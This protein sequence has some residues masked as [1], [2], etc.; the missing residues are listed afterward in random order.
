M[1]S[2]TS[3]KSIV[4]TGYGV[5]RAR[6]LRRRGAAGSAAPASPRRRCIHTWR[7]RVARGARCVGARWGRGAR[8]RLGE[9]GRRALDDDA[10][11]AMQPDHLD[12]APD[13]RLGAAYEQQPAGAAQA[14]RDEGD[15]EDERAVGERQ[16]GHVDDDIALRR[17]KSAGE[18]RAAPPPRR[19]VLVSRAAEGGRLFGELDD[20][21]ATYTT[22]GATLKP[23]LRSKRSRTRCRT[24]STP[25][26]GSTSS[27]SAS[28]TASRSTAGTST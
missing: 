22:G 10:G 4:P 3:G 26:W 25:S 12:D 5:D 1:K 9:G 14:P 15:V 2:R 18:G 13:L 7:A 24:S 17:R 8:R 11:Q 21:S 28:S 20:G 27:S 19:D 23:C 6:R 16:L